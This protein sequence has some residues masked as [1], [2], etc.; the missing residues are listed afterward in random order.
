LVLC[1]TFCL[2]KVCRFHPFDILFV[3]WFS[4]SCFSCYSLYNPCSELSIFSSRLCLVI[5]ANLLWLF[6]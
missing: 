2:I 4:Q 6:L 5:L 3:I 1:F